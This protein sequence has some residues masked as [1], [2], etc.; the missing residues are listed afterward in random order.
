MLWL[1]TKNAPHLAEAGHRHSWFAGD[2]EQAVH[3]SRGRPGSTGGEA[4]Q[5]APF[6]LGVYPT[7]A[8]RNSSCELSRAWFALG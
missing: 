6:G 1:Y 5:T 2:K 8:G 4:A 7:D 3:W